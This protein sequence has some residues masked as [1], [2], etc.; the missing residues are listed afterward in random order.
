M[1]NEEVSLSEQILA[2]APEEFK[3][4]KQTL[5]TTLDDA[6]R[7]LKSAENNLACEERDVEKE[8][9]RIDAL[10]EEVSK[11]NR[12]RKMEIETQNKLDPNVGNVELLRAREEVHA[13]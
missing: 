3:V 1:L 9:A 7:E 13:L 5:Q 12:E 10:R 6:K 8:K 4:L 11:W 2:S